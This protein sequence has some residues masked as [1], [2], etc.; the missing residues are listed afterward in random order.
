[1]LQGVEEEVVVVM[2]VS[3]ERESETH[4]KHFS[5]LFHDSANEK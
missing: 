4:I 2:P 1:V 5:F 3:E